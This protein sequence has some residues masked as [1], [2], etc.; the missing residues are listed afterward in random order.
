VDAGPGTGAGEGDGARADA[1]LAE[2]V[3]EQVG[4]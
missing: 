2:G 3:A 4:H 1:E